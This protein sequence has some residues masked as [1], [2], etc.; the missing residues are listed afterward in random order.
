MADTEPL[1]PPVE[2][3][4]EQGASPF[5]LL[6]EHASRFIPAA[7]GGLGV[8]EHDLT[9]H[10]AWDIGAANVAMALSAALDAPL[11]MAGYSRLLIDLNRPID[12]ETSIPDVSETTLIPGNAGLSAQE[13]ARRVTAYFTPFQT[14][15]SHLLDARLRASKLGRNCKDSMADKTRARVSGRTFGSSFS[16]RETVLMDTFAAAATS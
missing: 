6:C 12:S 7:Y 14:A 3:V 1:P 11:V 10:I 4:N 16:T 9:R 13:R 15:V 2:V 8:S 5:V